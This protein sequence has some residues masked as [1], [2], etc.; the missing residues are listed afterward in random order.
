[1]LRNMR[2]ARWCLLL[3]GLWACSAEPVAMLHQRPS[4]NGTIT[5]EGDSLALTGEL[6]F[7]RRE[8]QNCQFTRRHPTTLVLGRDREGRLFAFEG[9]HRA[10]QAE[11]TRQLR[12]VLALVDG[13]GLTKPQAGE[14]TYSVQLP[15][16]G[17]VRVTPVESAASS[18]GRH[19]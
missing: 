7:D 5:V 6:G 18:H 4:F 13:T 1:M 3:V 19:R 14:K 16:V 2:S 11:E 8:S 12:A 10:L 17:R 15:E 9:A